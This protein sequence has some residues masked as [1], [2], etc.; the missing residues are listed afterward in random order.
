M[1]CFTQHPIFSQLKSSAEIIVNKYRR[2]NIVKLFLI[3]RFFFLLGSFCF[4]T[5]LTF[6]QVKF[7]GMP[8]ELELSKLWLAWNLSFLWSAVV[9]AFI[10]ISIFKPSSKLWMNGVI[11]VSLLFDAG[12]IYITTLALGGINSSMYHTVYLLIAFHSY[13][14]PSYSWP[15]EKRLFRLKYLLGG[16]TASIL[17]SMTIFCR[18]AQ[19]H[20]QTLNVLLEFGLQIMT[21]I[22]LT[23]LRL[24]IQDRYKQSQEDNLLLKQTQ[25]A[26]ETLMLALQDVIAMAK[27][28]NKT[29]LKESLN[30]ICETI[31]EKLNVEFCSIGFCEQKRVER[32]AYWMAITTQQGE[33]VIKK[34]IERG[35]LKNTLLESVL[36]KYAKSF[37]WDSGKQGDLLDPT[38]PEFKKLQLNFNYKVAE[39]TRK[40][41]LHTQKISHL[42][43]I[44]LFSQARSVG[45]LGYLQ[46]INRLAYPQDRQNQKKIHAD[47]FAESQVKIME[48][49]ASQLAIAFENFQIHQDQVI[50]FKEEIFLNS[51]VQSTELDD[52]ITKSLQYLNRLTGSRVASLWVPTEDG[53]GTPEQITKAALRS[54]YIGDGNSQTPADL[55]LQENLQRLNIFALN[56]CYVGQ[57]L[58][59]DTGGTKIRYENNLSQITN[60]WAKFE[61]LI[62]SPQLLAIPLRRYSHAENSPTND[63]I[64]HGLTGFIILRP[65]NKNFDFTASLQT[66]FERFAAHLGIVIEQARYRKRYDQI[67]LLKDRLGQLPRIADLEQFSEILVDIVNEV[68]DA[69]ACS[70]FTFDS[71]S[72]SLLLKASTAAHFKKEIESGKLLVLEKENYIGKA[73][74]SLDGRSI[75]GE[76]FK[77]GTSALIYDVFQNAYVN[78]SFMEETDSGRHQSLIGAIIVKSNGDKLGV[79]RCINKRKKGSLPPIFIQ[80]DKEFME[81]IVGIIT[82]FVEN[83][84]KNAEKAEFLRQLSHEFATPLQAMDSQINFV[85][86]IFNKTVSVKD[87]EEQFQYLREETAF[88]KYMIQDI[89]FIYGKGANLKSQYSFDKLVDLRPVI[90]KVRKLLISNARYDKGIDIRGFTSQLP[91]LYVDRMRMEQVFFNLL[92][93]AVKYSK[94]GEHDIE[95]QYDQVSTGAPAERCHAI[96]IKNWGIGVIKDE[97]ELIFQEYKRGSNTI[98]TAVSGTGIGLSVSKE[99]VN[100]H[101][102]SLKVTRL[103]WPTI[104]TVYLPDYLKERKPSP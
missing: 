64:W 23:V 91:A 100:N 7:A 40:N 1:K 48:L 103:A 12:T 49:V 99:I 57:L 27:I 104:F 65:Q 45:P 95:I 42:L 58:T 17:C 97:Q 41:I 19:P 8:S 37:N 28:R 33:S 59:H 70:L 3:L 43:I 4:L 9:I 2:A 96:H 54:I 76:I 68:L 83:A 5:A 31:G 6:G 36:F 46:I 98:E 20:Q 71:K 75:T 15:S 94:I 78:K 52:I 25:A 34:Y 32:L 79:L 66:Q 62:N 87:P 53:I 26:Q 89:Q 55:R 82:G 56:D 92:H 22:T 29:E 47:G 77:S 74:Y 50:A 10:L 80:G 67:V 13:Y 18:L 86:S 30:K 39:D 51:L 81:L 44:P 90:D 14:F 38:N 60:C 102:G 101:D 16:G 24:K 84:E 85:E 61:S 72:K 35:D 93:N 63:P 69:E 73:I 11:G 21:A 88:L